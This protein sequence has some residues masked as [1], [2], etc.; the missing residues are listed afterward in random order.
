MNLSFLSAID[1]LSI[2]MAHTAKCRIHQFTRSNKKPHE[3]YALIIEACGPRGF[4]KWMKWNE[5]LPIDSEK[6][7]TMKKKK[8][9]KRELKTVLLN[10][11]ITPCLCFGF[12]VGL[13]LVNSI[14]FVFLLVVVACDIVAV[15]KPN[16]GFPPA[17][18]CSI[19]YPPSNAIIWRTP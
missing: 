15:A 2:A 10:N 13:Q 3:C 19:L 4:H 17:E 12:W 9:E 11:T 1:Q 6:K 8:K 5:M 16:A 18:L 14:V 7:E